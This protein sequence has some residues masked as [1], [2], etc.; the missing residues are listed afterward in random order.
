MEFSGALCEQQRVEVY[1]LDHCKQTD[2]WKVT[3]RILAQQ[4]QP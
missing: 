4:S 1:G 2:I 3:S